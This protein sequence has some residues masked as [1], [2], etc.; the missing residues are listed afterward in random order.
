MTRRKHQM[1]KI[2]TRW[3]PPTLHCYVWGRNDS[4]ER[5]F[6]PDGLISYLNEGHHEDG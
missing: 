6:A 1:T 2:L 3:P 4:K 5:V